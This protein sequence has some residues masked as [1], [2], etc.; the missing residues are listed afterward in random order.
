ML[1]T[2]RNI[3]NKIYINTNLRKRTCLF[4]DSKKQTHSKTWLWSF[5]S[6][7][8]QMDCLFNLLEVST[9]VFIIVTGQLTCVVF[10]IYHGRDSV[11]AVWCHF[12]VIRRGPGGEWGWLV[13]WTYLLNAT[14]KHALDY[15]SCISY[16][17]LMIW[18]GESLWPHIVCHTFQYDTYL[19]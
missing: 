16:R 4:L 2:S 19:F 3:E 14:N 15:V 13:Y 10:I 6:S 7:I 1:V 9:E 17:I 8:Y 5:F 11:C 12:Q 18:K